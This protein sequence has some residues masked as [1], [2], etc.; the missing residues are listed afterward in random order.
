MKKLFYITLFA[1]VNA[2]MLA[3]IPNAGFEVW[4]PASGYEYPANWGVLAQATNGAAV[5]CEKSTDKYSGNFAARL[6]TRDLVIARVPGLLFTGKL[7][8]ATQSVSGGFAYDQQ[9]ARLTG[10]YKYTPGVGDS[11][12]VFGLL[13]R[14]LAGGA[15]D[16]VATFFWRGGAAASYS[17]FSIPLTYRSNAK[18][19]TALIVISSSKDPV[20][21]ALNSSMWVDALS[22]EGSVSI[23]EPTS[24]L[25]VAVIPNPAQETIRLSV[26]Y[27]G[28]LRVWLVDA[29]GQ[30]VDNQ[31]LY[32]GEALPVGHLPTGTYFLQVLD[33]QTLQPLGHASFQRR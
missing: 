24:L 21:P 32:S 22:F 8:V 27:E 3:Q 16:T 2:V 1:S 9:P 13:T 31:L 7:D 18:P 15:R 10:Y 17:P 33:A 29:A 19:D 11:C 12:T 4:Q 26:A 30:L 23:S 5:T 6:F 14:T 25:P 20:A 28:L